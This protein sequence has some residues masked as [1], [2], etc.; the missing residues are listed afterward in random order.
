MDPAFALSSLAG[1]SPA[2]F[3]PSLSI[4]KMGIIMLPYFYMA[5]VKMTSEVMHVKC[6]DH[7]K[8]LYECSVLLLQLIEDD[9]DVISTVPCYNNRILF[10]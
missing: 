8:A 2:T 4:C 9:N 3:S 5:A 1:L 6:F 10:L 7:L